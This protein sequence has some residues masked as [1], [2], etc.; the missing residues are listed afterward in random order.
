M[1]D[2][3]EVEDWREMF[4]GQY[5]NAVT[6]GPPNADRTVQIE[7]VAGRDVETPD[8]EVRRRVVVHLA[9]LKPWLLCR[10]TAECLSAMWGPAVKEWA[11]QAVTLFHD[12]TVRAGPKVVGG[13]RVRGAPGLPRPVDVEIAMPKRKPLK[14]R[15]VNTAQKG[16]DKPLTLAALGLTRAGV[17]ALLASLGKPPATDAGLPAILTRLAASPDHLSRARELSRPGTSP[18]PQPTTTAPADD[19]GPPDLE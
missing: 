2:D 8:G 5:L 13:I 18:N 9:G 6:L 15:L 4:G 14:I 11:G 16:A 7:R 12:P 10:T 3:Y 19:D 1:A 17:D